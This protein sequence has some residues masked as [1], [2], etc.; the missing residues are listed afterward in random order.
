M[1]LEICLPVVKVRGTAS[2]HLVKYSV[3]IMIN[4]WPSEEGGEIALI[5]S[6]ANW[7][8]G[9]GETQAVVPVLVHGLGCYVS[10]T[11]DKFLQS[12]EHPV[13]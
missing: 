3:A 11:Y 5:R 2:T 8:K 1:N 6:N 13:P 12:C 10:D 7:E 9:H 4:L